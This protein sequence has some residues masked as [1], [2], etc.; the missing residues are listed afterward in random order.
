MYKLTDDKIEQFLIESSMMQSHLIDDG[1]PTFYKS[2]GEYK[3]NAK[4]WMD[5]LYKE[6]G[7]KVIDYM[8]RK[9]AQDPGY[10]YELRYRA[11]GAV[12]YLDSGVKSGNTDAIEKYKKR[13]E[14]NLET[15]GWTITAWLGVEAAHDSLIGTVLSAGV[16]K[17]VNQDDLEETF[18]KEWW[19]KELLKEAGEK[20]WT[21]MSV[22]AQQDYISKHKTSKKVQP[23]NP[24][25]KKERDHEPEEGPT[26]KNHEKYYV[27]ENENSK[28]IGTLHKPQ[29]PNPDDYPKGTKDP[30][31][32]KALTK[33]KKENAKFM[34]FYEETV[35][36]EVEDFLNTHG[37][38]NVVFMPEG[39]D[40]GDNYK[41]GSEQH[42]VADHVKGQGGTVD[43][44]DGPEMSQ[45]VNQEGSKDE[46]GDDLFDRLSKNSKPPKTRSQ[47]AAGIYAMMVGQGDDGGDAMEYM[48]ESSGVDQKEAE[49]YLKDNG[50]VGSIPPKNKSEKRHLY[51]LAFPGDASEKEKK[52]YNIKEPNGVSEVTDS[53]NK[54]RQNNMIKKKEQYENEGKKVLVVPGASH[55]FEM[56]NEFSEKKKEERFSIEAAKKGFKAQSINENLKLILEI[57]ERMPI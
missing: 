37:A 2:F 51:L 14:K 42:M 33:Y 34:D 41:E 21:D 27:H 36:K 4:S 18:S 43:T 48:G 44:F 15:L 17:K 31:Y 22:D 7:W 23:D 40:E 8:I 30:K 39:G 1:P 56:R 57:D 53:H 45:W 28:I 54:A 12:S 52:K 3:T 32:K 6:L 46:N 49:Q 35:K 26:Q 16:G 29:K 10:D 24:S 50:Y 47:S 5:E 25:G 9:N 13:M 55:A 11:L 19:S 38:E 20:Y